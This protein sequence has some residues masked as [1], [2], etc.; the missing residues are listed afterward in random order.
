VEGS[1]SLALFPQLL[2]PRSGHLSERGVPELADEFLQP[3]LILCFVD[4]GCSARLV[5]S[6]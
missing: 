5:N 6:I 4:E 1:G 3:G 2:Q